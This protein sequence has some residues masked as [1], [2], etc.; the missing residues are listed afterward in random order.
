M[1]N[2]QHRLDKVRSPRVQITYDV[3]IGNEQAAKE[4]PLVIGVMGDFTHASEP[5][6]ERKFISIDKSNFNEIMSSMKPNAEFLVESVLPELNGSLPVA[7]TFRTIEDFSPDQFVLQVE[8]LRKLIA[9]R[10][11]LSDLRNRAAS[12]ER[13]KEQLA[14]TV[15][16]MKEKD[17]KEAEDAQH[18]DKKDEE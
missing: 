13:L 9:L 7:L 17:A 5:L 15:Q 16:Q 8:P 3:E 1:N 14:D 12:N 10:E 6:K 18:S 11:Q 2:T 4:L